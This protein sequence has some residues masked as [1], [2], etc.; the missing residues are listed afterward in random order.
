M[1]RLINYAAALGALAALASITACGSS[2]VV[3]ALDDRPNAGPCPTAGAIY[4]AARIIEFSDERESF[5][6]IAYSGE[7]TGVRLFC[8]YVEDEP[9]LAE[10]EI[11]FAF[12]KGPKGESRTHEYPYFVA[13]TRRNSR[14]LNRQN[15]LVT[16][17]FR[18]GQIAT[19]QE[20]V[21]RV[22]IPR[23]D[24]TISGANFEV[25]VG[26][27][28]TEQQ[29]AFNQAGKRFRLDAGG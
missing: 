28:L 7:I 19:A 24:E 18:S 14:V 10:V 21:N 13:V 27:D 25:L 6:N 22:V 20:L 15:F 5:R 8:R 4:E 26:F 9:L 17:D 11:D 3:R 1:G 16:A 29:L 2:G 12:G 23:V